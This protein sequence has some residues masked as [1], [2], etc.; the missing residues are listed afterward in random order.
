MNGPLPRPGLRVLLAA[1]AIAAGAAPGANA[2]PDGEAL[3]RIQSEPPGASVRIDGTHR[4]V[5]PLTLEEIPPGEHLLSLSAPGYRDH[6]QTLTLGAG[7]RRTVDVALEPLTGLALVHSDPPGAEITIGGATYGRTPLLLTTLPFGS[8][9]LDFSREGHES[10]SIDVTI[11]DRRPFKVS[12]ALPSTSGALS[13]AS[14][15]SGAEVFVNGIPQGHTP[16]TVPRIPAEDPVRVRVSAEGYEPFEQT[17]RLTPGHTETL[18]I[19]LSPRPSVL[20]VTSEPPGARL[21]VNGRLR[22]ITPLEI[23]DL[24]PGEYTLALEL[25]GYDPLTRTVRLEKGKTRTELFL[26]ESNTGGIMLTTEP[27]GV[28]VLL[29]DVP[30]GETEAPE[31]GSDRISKP[32]AMEAVPAGLRRLRLMRRGFFD[33]ELQVEVERGKTA[34]LHAELARRFIPDYEVTT[35]RR[36]YRGVLDSIT[37]EA[38]RLETAP[39]ITTT[40]D[41]R[42][43]RRHGPWREEPE[44]E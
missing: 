44:P 36:V 17:L 5:T 31:T 19:P 35:D 8:Y 16:V 27:A 38:I 21:R 41:R 29:D 9:R 25:R 22:G 40:I 15:P 6:H 7:T 1:L 23:N 20:K 39:G 42:N 26:L 34:T 18:T 32:F 11:K 14:D 12:V 3:L 24:P 30:L 2:P 28:T 33:R 10:R 4:G 37:P 13:V 43:V